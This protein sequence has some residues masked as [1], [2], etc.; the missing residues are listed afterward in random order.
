[1]EAFVC[2]IPLETNGSCSFQNVL[3]KPT[4]RSHLFKAFQ[5]ALWFY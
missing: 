1:M 4:P 3:P 2:Q 5:G